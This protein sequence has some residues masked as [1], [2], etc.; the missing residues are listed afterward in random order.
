MIRQHLS[1]GP[2]AFENWMVENQNGLI[3]VFFVYIVFF[4]ILVGV[5]GYIGS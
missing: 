3:I 2:D 5:L 1:K 4:Y